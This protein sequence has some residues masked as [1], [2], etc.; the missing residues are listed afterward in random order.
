VRGQPSPLPELPIQYADYAAWQQD[1][2]DGPS[3]R[4]QLAY[5]KD[6]L[7]DAP[8]GLELPTDR[9]RQALRSK[10]GERHFLRMPRSLRDGLAAL[11]RRS[12]ATL[13]IGLLAAFKVLLYRYGGQTDIAVGSPHAGRNQP[14]TEGLIGCFSNTLVLR[15][16]LSGELTFRQLLGRVREV[17]LGAYAHADV[18]FERIVRELRPR[19]DPSRMALFQVNFRLLTAPPPPSRLGPVELEFLEVDNRRAKFDLS[20]EFGEKADTLAGYIEYYADLFDRATIR[21]MGEDFESLLGAVVGHPDIPLQ[22]LDVPTHSGA[23]RTAPAPRVSNSHPGESMKR[24][25]SDVRRRAA[26]LPPAADETDRRPPSADTGCGRYR[27]RP[28]GPKDCEFLYALRKRTMAEFVEQYPDWT[29]AHR[30]AF[31]MDF[32]PA[33]HSIIVVDGRDAGAMAVRRTDREFYFANLHLLPDF[34][35]RWLGTWIFR[36]LMAE[37]DTRGVPI[38][39]HVMKNN[40]ARRLYERLGFSICAET[41]IRYEMTRPAP[42]PAQTP[43]ATE[44]DRERERPNSNSE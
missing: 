37:A 40:P 24:Q 5:W 1:W 12:G 25:L 38:R 10:R 31:Y 42:P 18:P 22:S 4:A 30:E 20:V 43:S 26:P 33:I 21:R 39:F 23:G 3:Y 32:D 16:R 34:Q 8:P 44:A 6:Q 7:G 14:E 9:P 36:D 11:A 2:L 41:D 15:S 13:Y 19:R 17:A 35:G 29:E 28:A 27:L